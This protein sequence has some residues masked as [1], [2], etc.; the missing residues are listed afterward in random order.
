MDSQPGSRCSH[1][2]DIDRVFARFSAPGAAATPSR[3]TVTVP[4]RGTRGS[5]VVEV[6]H[7]GPRSGAAE[8]V[9]ARH[10]ADIGTAA[11]GEEVSS[12]GPPPAQATAMPL[13]AA[14]PSPQPVVHVM[15]AWQPRAVEVQPAP[16]IGRSAVPSLH[17]APKTPRRTRSGPTFRRVADPFDADDDGTNCIRCGYLVEPAREKRGLMTCAGCV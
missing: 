3:Q 13:P 1:M 17:P 4:A 9:P 7:L 14:P 8:A 16:G 10:A 6:V 5:R 15:P 2:T 12:K 11:W